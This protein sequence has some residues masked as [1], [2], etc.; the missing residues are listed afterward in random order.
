MNRLFFFI[1]FFIVLLV[2]GVEAAVDV[3]S[4]RFT[5]TSGLGNNSV[6]YMYQ[7]SKG[8]IWMGTLNGLSR[9]DGTSFITF[10]PRKGNKP[11]LPD[12]RIQE[13]IEDQNCFLWIK[14]TGESV[15]CYDLKKDCFV[16]FTGSGEYLR[17][18][19]NVYFVNKNEAWVTGERE[20]C[21]LIRYRKDRTFTS[22]AFDVRSGL[23]SNLIRD[24]KVGAE[25]WAWIATGKGL[26]YWDG[27]KLHAVDERMDFMRIAVHG[28]KT[29]FL[30]NKGAVYTFLNGALKK[31]VS[32]EGDFTYYDNL[33]LGKKWVIFS[34]T[35][36]W[37][38]DFETHVLTL[39]EEA[40]QI[41]RAKVIKDNKGESWVYGNSGVLT[42]IDSQSGKVTPFLLM[43][44][45]KRN[46]VD[47][48][49][50]YVVHD[51]RGII[52]IGTYGNGLFVYDVANAR[53]SSII[54]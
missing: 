9:F 42:W 16:D 44:E 28:K 34:G 48:E 3:R 51:S 38:F 32:I 24:L 13:I 31:E 41:K 29:Y 49:R 37:S 36:T 18:Y 4:T 14:T 19:S 26:Y 53:I 27:K 22:I 2:E 30:T 33:I 35:N 52:W 25:G 54:V 15:G 43:P 1:F 21:R 45:E 17:H 7:D 12:H 11:S 47:R 23:A 46:Y 40:L 20:G 39:A 10:R 50:Y 6:R 5:T 8:F